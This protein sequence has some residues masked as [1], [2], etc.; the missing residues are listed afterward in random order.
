MIFSICHAQAW[1]LLLHNHIIFKR[2]IKDLTTIVQ[3][4]GYSVLIASYMSYG[5]AH[6][7][8]KIPLYLQARCELNEYV[9]DYNFNK[10]VSLILIYFRLIDILKRM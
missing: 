2:F 1:W 10:V 3:P 4:N 7:V 6:M 5:A 8:Y 9:Y